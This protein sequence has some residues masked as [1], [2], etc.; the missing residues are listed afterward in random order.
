MTGAG[1]LISRVELFSPSTT[2]D[3][4]GQL[5]YSYATQGTAYAMVEERV[6]DVTVA[7][8]T[9]QLDQYRLTVWYDPDTT[10]DKGWRIEFGTRTLEVTSVYSNEDVGDFTYINARHLRG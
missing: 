4:A 1:D 7:D 9:E 10:I 3:D 8:G 6:S 2:R 5:T